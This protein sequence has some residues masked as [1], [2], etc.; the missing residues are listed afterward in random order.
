MTPLTAIV[1]PSP[2]SPCGSPTS[3]TSTVA[4][5]LPGTYPTFIVD[6][7]WGIKFF[8]RLFYG[9]ASFEVE[10]QANILLAAIP[11]IPAP[12]LIASGSLFPDSDGWPWHHPGHQLPIFQ[13][14]HLLTC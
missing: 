3:P 5:T 9:A 13:L 10:R 1:T 7:R 6:G 14:S 11:S 8:G 12:R 2:T 4:P